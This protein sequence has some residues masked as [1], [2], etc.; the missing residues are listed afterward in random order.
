VERPELAAEVNDRS[1]VVPS[2]EAQERV[3]AGLRR[4]LRRLGEVH[5]LE[6]G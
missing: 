2:E 3:W 1:E 4:D 6:F 5:G